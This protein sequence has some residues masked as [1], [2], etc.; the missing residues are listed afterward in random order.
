MISGYSAADPCAKKPCLNG[1][2]CTE[3]GNNSRSCQCAVGYSGEN[4]E[5]STYRHIDCKLCVN[6]S[7]NIGYFSYLSFFCEPT[8]NYDL[9]QIV[10]CKL[11][12]A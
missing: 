9:L 11:R 8:L 1:G 3:T 12:T 7:C 10:P 4:C 6:N 5:K 2:I